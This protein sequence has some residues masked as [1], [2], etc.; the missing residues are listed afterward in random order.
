MATVL[1]RLRNDSPGPRIVYDAEHR[2]VCL[3]PGEVRGVMLASAVASG[4][5]SRPDLR[6]LDAIDDWIEARAAAAQSS[7]PLALPPLYVVGMLGFGDNLH[8]RAV[9]REL[10]KTRAVTLATCHGC[11]YHDL[12]DQGLV[13]TFQR[14]H[15]RTQAKLQ[16][17]EKSLM[18]APVPMG[19]ETR[20]MFYGKT[21]IDRHGTILGA[22][23][24][25]MGLPVPDR[26][27]FSL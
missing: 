25:A 19:V 6:V 2:E 27:D 10:M 22:M 1:L 9:L 13:L 8:Q 16:A 23:F 15:L 18:A 11:I 3:K 14:A 12:V 7:W 5:Y 20:R 21:E 26:P 4:L 17:R 24:A